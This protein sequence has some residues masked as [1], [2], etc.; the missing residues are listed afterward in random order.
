MLEFVSADDGVLPTEQATMSA[1]KI[2]PI[3]AQTNLGL[4]LD[5]AAVKPILLEKDGVVFR[6]AG[7][8]ARPEN[9]LHVNGPTASHQDAESALDHL[10]QV[11]KSISHGQRFVE[12][13]TELI[14]A[15]RIE[16]TA[17][18]LRAAGSLTRD[19]PIWWEAAYC[20]MEHFTRVRDAIVEDR[21][22]DAPEHE[23]AMLGR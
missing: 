22:V 19:D 2:V 23:T 12:D 17:Q 13:S 20:T 18:L 11:R 21:P 8:L 5:E 4:L 16:R 9:D 10:D 1:S 14:R 15:S 3:T 7:A 6:L